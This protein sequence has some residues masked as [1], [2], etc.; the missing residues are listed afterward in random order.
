[1]FNMSNTTVPPI[2]Q[3]LLTLPDF[4][5]Q[6]KGP[7]GK[8]ASPETYYHCSVTHVKHLMTLMVAL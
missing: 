6:N 7:T 3:E 4:I 5:V 1:M 8:C 2:E